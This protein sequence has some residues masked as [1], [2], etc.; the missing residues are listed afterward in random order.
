[1]THP[2]NPDA[3]RVKR[4]GPRGWHWVAAFDPAIHQLYETT[5]ENPAPKPT[6][7]RKA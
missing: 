5:A 4:D 3:V 7:A 6:R 2:N 1:M